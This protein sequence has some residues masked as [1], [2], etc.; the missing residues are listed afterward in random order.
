V[1]TNSIS[2][3]Q[4]IEVPRCC[5]HF[6]PRLETHRFGFSFH[7]QGCKLRLRCGD[8]NLSFRP[9]FSV[10]VLTSHFS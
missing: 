10:S 2:S 1:R 4:P 9:C 8:L 5:R 7:G 3:L 6:G